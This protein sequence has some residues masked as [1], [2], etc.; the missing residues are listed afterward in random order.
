MSQSYKL[1]NVSHKSA[2]YVCINGYDHSRIWGIWAVLE[3]I[4]QTEHDS[5]V[6]VIMEKRYCKIVCTIP[7][8]DTGPISMIPKSSLLFRRLL[9][10]LIFLPINALSSMIDV[11]RDSNIRI[12]NYYYFSLYELKV[13]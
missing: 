1:L 3:I 11:C 12:F 4:V 9:S 7:D 13:L 10:L 5:S 8:E 6:N 2:Q